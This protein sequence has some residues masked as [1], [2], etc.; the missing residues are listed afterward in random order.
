[1]DGRW[2]DNKPERLGSGAFRFYAFHDP[3]TGKDYF[4]YAGVQGRGLGPERSETPALEQEQKL[5][6]ELAAIAL[7][8]HP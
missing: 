2:V 1:M 4:M 3:R 8:F 6:G 7:S 5:L